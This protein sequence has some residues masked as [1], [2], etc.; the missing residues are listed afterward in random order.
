MVQVEYKFEDYL[1]LH[2]LNN[3]A[4]NTQFI[5]Y[6]LALDHALDTLWPVSGAVCRRFEFF[7]ARSS[8][9]ATKRCLLAQVG[10]YLF[11]AAALGLG[12]HGADEDEGEYPDH[13]VPEERY[14]WSDRG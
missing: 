14:A 6:K 9:T 3:Y 8:L 5:P 10:L 11:E 7:Q 2:G 13:G 4:T 12:D 1:G